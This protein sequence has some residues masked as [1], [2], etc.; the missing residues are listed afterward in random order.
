MPGFL[1]ALEDSLVS[2][3]I[4][5]LRAW[6]LVFPRTLIVEAVSITSQSS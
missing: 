2:L 1:E 4:L 5:V 6:E 3:A